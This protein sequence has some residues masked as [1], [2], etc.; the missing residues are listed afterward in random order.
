MEKVFVVLYGHSEYCGFDIF[1]GAFKT[2]QSALEHAQSRRKK[3]YN[4]VLTKQEGNVTYVLPLK[5]DDEDYESKRNEFEF[6]YDQMTYYNGGY[7]IM[8]TEVK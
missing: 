5:S 4:E 7:I 3:W 8:E 1:G 2:L 6:D